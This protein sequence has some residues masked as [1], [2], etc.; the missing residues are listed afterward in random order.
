MLFLLLPFE[1]PIPAS[2]GPAINDS[3]CLSRFRVDELYSFGGINPF[4]IIFV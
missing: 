4:F 1:E 3:I 2:G